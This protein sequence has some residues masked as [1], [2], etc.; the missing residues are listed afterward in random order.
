M[1]FHQTG[2]AREK[3]KG[4]QNAHKTKEKDGALIAWLLLGQAGGFI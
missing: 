2:L 4:G 3:R 1:G